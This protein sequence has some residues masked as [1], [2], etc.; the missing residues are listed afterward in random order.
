MKTSGYEI[1]ELSTTE[2][3]A[4][5]DVTE[6]VQRTVENCGLTDGIVLVYCPH[7]TGGV[8]INEGAD[9][10]VQEDL[11][12]FFATLVP[13]AW[14][15]DHKEGNSDS[16]VKTSMIGASETVIVAG[17][18]LVLGTW[19]RIFFCEFDGPRQR[20]FFVKPIAG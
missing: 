14:G 11:K 10:D 19:Q 2:R 15:F 13:Q 8:T 9:P 12:R 4:M 3:L 1:V 18:Q 7:T 20:R 5:I 17:G 16:H 6:E